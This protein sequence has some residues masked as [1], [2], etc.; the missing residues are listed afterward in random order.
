MILKHV[1]LREKIYNLQDTKVYFIFLIYPYFQPPKNPKRSAVISQQ[2]HNHKSRVFR[3]DVRY[4]ED[5]LC[6]EAEVAS[7]MLV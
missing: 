3:D 4:N 5:Y 1:H 2:T 7:T 6:F